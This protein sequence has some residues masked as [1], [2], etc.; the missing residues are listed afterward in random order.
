[1][2]NVFWTGVYPGM[3]KEM[4]DFMVTKIGELCR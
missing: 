1:M 2:T 3:T 4:L